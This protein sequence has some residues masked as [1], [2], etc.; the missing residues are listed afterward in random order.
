MEL[1]ELSQ[2]IRSIRK[3]KKLTQSKLSK[4]TAIS[5]RTIATIENN[6]EVDVGIIKMEKIL[7]TLGY[8][9]DIRPK[10]RPLTLD[11]LNRNNK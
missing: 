10:G 2:T 5:T 8:E 6:F 7:N 11:E 1:A 9:L 4:L 3:E